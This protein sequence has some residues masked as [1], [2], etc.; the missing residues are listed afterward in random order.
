[1][2]SSDPLQLEESGVGNDI[3][4]AASA[5][6]PNSNH[7]RQRVPLFTVDRTAK[8]VTNAAQTL[9][10]Q[11][12]KDPESHQLFLQCLTSVWHRDICVLAQQFEEYRN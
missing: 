1:M 3:C 7:Q 6:S 8:S 4:Y 10:D 5:D 9:E 2:N 11:Q 12:F